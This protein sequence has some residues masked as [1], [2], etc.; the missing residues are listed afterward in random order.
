MIAVLFRWIA[1]PKMI[2]YESILNLIT[3]FKKCEAKMNNQYE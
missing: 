3:E 1:S 2:A